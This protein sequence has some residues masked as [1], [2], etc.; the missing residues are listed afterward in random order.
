MPYSSNFKSGGPL[1]DTPEGRAKYHKAKC[2][3]ARDAAIALVASVALLPVTGGATAF[4]LP[5]VT[6]NCF[7][8]CLEVITSKPSSAP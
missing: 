6:I 2:E 5:F 4:T 8:Q 3:D 7:A 1:H